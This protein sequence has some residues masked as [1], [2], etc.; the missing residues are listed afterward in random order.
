MYRASRALVEKDSVSPAMTQSM[1]KP[2]QCQEEKI[3][4]T[5]A[6]LIGVRS[7]SGS[8]TREIASARSSSLRYGA[9]VVEGVSG[10][11]NM[12]YRAM[13]TVIRPSIWSWIC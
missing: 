10:K 3:R 1:T 7:R 11:R 5:K 13:G 4:L 8:G 6:K 2:Y 9:L 12:P